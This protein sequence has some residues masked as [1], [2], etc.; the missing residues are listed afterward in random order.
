LDLH[1]GGH[2]AAVKP[3]KGKLDVMTKPDGNINNPITAKHKGDKSRY[4]ADHMENGDES[5]DDLT[6]LVYCTKSRTSIW[7]NSFVPIEK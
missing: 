2:K 7:N 3:A 6:E 1:N 4:Y 5:D